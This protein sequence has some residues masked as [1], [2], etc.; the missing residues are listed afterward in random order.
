MTMLTGLIL[1]LVGLWIVHRN[2][3]ISSK[4]T[5]NN[6][7]RGTPCVC[8]ELENDFANLKQQHTDAMKLVQAT[9][10]QVKTIQASARPNELDAMVA[11]DALAQLAR[12]KAIIISLGTRYGICNEDIEKL[13]AIIDVE[14]E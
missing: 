13:L 10:E 5:T 11:F 7:C 14:K 6:V 4:A 1:F 12:A 2:N 3:R 8:K 9:L